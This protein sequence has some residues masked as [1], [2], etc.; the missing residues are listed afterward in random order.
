[1]TSDGPSLTN[2]SAAAIRELND[3]L[4]LAERVSDEVERLEVRLLKVSAMYFASAGCAFG[5]FF[6][7]NYAYTTLHMLSVLIVGALTTIMGGSWA[8]YS[9][10]VLVRKTRRKFNSEK[11]VL[12]DLVT[13]ASDLVVHLQAGSVIERALLKT[14]L[15]RLQLYTINSSDN[16]VTVVNRMGSAPAPDHPVD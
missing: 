14:K 4:T 13:M 5:G 3:L 11:H 15:R 16:I 1:M 7:A 6:L 12:N 2:E 10:L 9:L 8:A